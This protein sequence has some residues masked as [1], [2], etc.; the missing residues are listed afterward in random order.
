MSC[1]DLYLSIYFI[2]C[3]LVQVGTKINI[4]RVNRKMKFQRLKEKEYY[5]NKWIDKNWIRII[6]NRRDI[7]VFFEYMDV[8]TSADNSCVLSHNPSFS[9]QL[10]YSRY[11]H[12]R[13]SLTF[14]LWINDRRK[15]CVINFTCMKFTRI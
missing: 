6:Y 9:I 4:R 2:A 3:T 7:L 15:S 11:N 14:I 10:Q 8:R 1:T 5:Q 12:V 13:F